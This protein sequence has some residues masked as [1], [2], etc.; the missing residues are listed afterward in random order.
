M[1]E[2]EE[3]GKALISAAIMSPALAH[4]VR[5]REEAILRPF[6]SIWILNAKY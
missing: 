2:E 1:E 5:V 6:Q 4:L 3:D